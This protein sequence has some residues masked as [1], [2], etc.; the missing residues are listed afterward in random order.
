MARL[1]GMTQAALK[2]EVRPA[3]VEGRRVPAP[4]P[5][6]PARARAAGS[7]DARLPRRRAAPARARASTSSCSSARSA[8]PSPTSPRRSP[9]ELGGGRVRWGEQLDVR[10]LAH[11]R[12]S[13]ARS[14]ATWPSTRPRAPSRPAGCC[15]ASTPTRSTT[16]RCAS[17]SA[18][19]C[20]PRSTLDAAAEAARATPRRTR[21]AG[22]RRRDRLEPGRARD[23]RAARDEHR[24]A[25]ARP[26]ST[27][28]PRTSAASSR[29]LD[30]AAERARHDARGRA[31]HRRARAPGRRRLDRPGQRAGSRAAIGATRGWRAC[32]HAFGYRGHCLTKSRRYST[33]FKALREAR[34]AFVHEQ[35]LARSTDATQ[36]AIAAATPSAHRGVRV[37]RRRARNSRRRVLAASAA[38]R[39]REHRRLA[40]EESAP[41]LKGYK[42]RSTEVRDERP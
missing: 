19:T 1:A 34:E 42:H 25:A 24:R 17:T 13:A 31:R 3:Y 14:P 18:A 5:G 12:R 21:P 8:R 22:G 27:T 41:G 32:A 16:P 30:D 15:T 37:R 6:A 7:R 23:P 33:T 4:R 40:R 20:A 9:A 39:A 10:Q 36:R 29:L 11:R 28:A 38:A 2:R 26:R 35:I